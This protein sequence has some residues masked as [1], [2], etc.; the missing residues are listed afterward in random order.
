MIYCIEMTRELEEKVVL[1]LRFKLPPT[2][3]EILQFVSEEGY[4]FDDN[5]GKLIYYKVSD[6][7]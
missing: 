4:H 3:D 1:H 5:Y 2:R 6:A 7:T